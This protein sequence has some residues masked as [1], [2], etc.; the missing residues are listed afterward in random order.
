MQGKEYQQINRSGNLEKD[1]DEEYQQ[2]RPYIDPDIYD[3]EK[4]GSNFIRREPSRNP[5]LRK[6]GKRKKYKKNAKPK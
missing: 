2:I 6:G 1:K 3:S 4:G 5:D